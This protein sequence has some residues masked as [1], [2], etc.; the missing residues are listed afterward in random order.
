MLGDSEV[1]FVCSDCGEPVVCI[2]IG[3]GLWS[4]GA[5]KGFRS[6][7]MVLISS[8]SACHVATSLRRFRTRGLTCIIVLADVRVVSELD[9]VDCGQ[10]LLRNTLL[11]HKSAFWIRIVP[12]RCDPGSRC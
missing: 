11:L 4:N 12:G 8:Y 7:N 2:A 10:A 1:V 3:L 5:S 9:L 6:C